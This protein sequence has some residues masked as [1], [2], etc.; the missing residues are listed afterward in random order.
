MKTAC[1]V[2]EGLEEKGR[3][4]L[5]VAF[6]CTAPHKSSGPATDSRRGLL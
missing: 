1:E 6:A 5:V 2:G 3:L 4:E